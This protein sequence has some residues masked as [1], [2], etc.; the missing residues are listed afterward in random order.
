M[1]A[2]FRQHT[3]KQWS[4]AYKAN[5]MGFFGIQKREHPWLSIFLNI[6]FFFQCKMCFVS[7]CFNTMKL[8]E[9]KNLL[10]FA[11]VFKFSFVCFLT[12]ILITHRSM[13]FNAYPGKYRFYLQLKQM[14]HFKVCDVDRVGVNP[15]IF[16][17]KCLWKL[18]LFWQLCKTCM[19]QLNSL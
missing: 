5:A 6:D 15:F 19:F 3:N 13:H 16:I 8:K 7:L 1:F 9:F 4:M 2:L 10:L 11:F 12:Q 17:A 14:T 18:F